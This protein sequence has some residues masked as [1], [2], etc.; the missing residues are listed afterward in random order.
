LVE[1]FLESELDISLFRPCLKYLRL[2]LDTNRKGAEE[3]NRELLEWLSS[4]SRAERPF[5]A[6]LNYFDAHSP[7]H[8][9]PGRT[10]RFGAVPDDNRQR[11]LILEWVS[12]DKKQLTPREIEF[13]ATSY[14]ECLAD[15]DEQIG[16]L[17]DELER[18]GVLERTWLLV[19]A[20]HGESFGEHE[21]VFCHGSSLYQS[22]IH[23]PLVI[24]PPGGT[25][26]RVV[27]DAVSLRDLAATIV[28]VAGM[29]D[30]SPLAGSSLARLWTEGKPPTGLPPDSGGQALTEVVPLDPNKYDVY[31]LPRTTWP[32]GG[33]VDGEWSYVR[34]EHDAHDELFHLRV[35]RNEQ[36]N[37]AGDPEARATLERMRAKLN[38]LTAGPLTRERFKP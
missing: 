7:Y 21:G 1:D 31:G 22:E 15:L 32:L 13:A 26:K 11:E 12:L 29:S 38:D 19:V 9:A 10:Y 33:L 25:A 4:R 30:G 28:H 6:F 17:C 35:D 20:D 24:V 23:V 18:R 3:V 34:R 5:F 37:R 27:K 36:R 8:V 16:I 14:D 2:L